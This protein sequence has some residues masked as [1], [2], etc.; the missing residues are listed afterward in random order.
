MLQELYISYL[1]CITIYLVAVLI[2]S[3]FGP[4]ASLFYS[5]VTI[6]LSRRSADDDG[7]SSSSSPSFTPGFGDSNLVMYALREAEETQQRERFRLA[8][9]NLTDTNLHPVDI[10]NYSDSGDS[11]DTQTPTGAVGHQRAKLAANSAVSGVHPGI[12]ELSSSEEDG[13][14]PL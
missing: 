6:L 5:A 2:Y 14:E 8:R 7:R 12:V 10:G 11:R 3:R 13:G 4:L 9:L 1:Y